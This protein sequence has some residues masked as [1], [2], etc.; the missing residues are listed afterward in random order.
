MTGTGLRSLDPYDRAEVLRSLPRR[1]HQASDC[2]WC[3]SRG[4]RQRRQ[5]KGV[6]MPRTSADGETSRGPKVPPRT[7]IKL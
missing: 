6:G 5:E 3:L 2:T 4:N 1:R 7:G